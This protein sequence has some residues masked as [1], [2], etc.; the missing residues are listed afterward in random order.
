MAENVELKCPGCGAPLGAP[1]AN[2]DHRC[3]YCGHTSRP[4]APG[5]GSGPSGG[6]LGVWMARLSREQ[7]KQRAGRAEV[8]A[9]ERAEAASAQRNGLLFFTLFGAAF[10][11]CG[12]VLCVSTPPA[13]RLR[14]VI[15]AV[16][17][18]AITL[19][20]IGSFR[21]ERKQRWLL[22]NGARGRGTVLS[23]R[24]RG[25]KFDLVLRVELPNRPPYELKTTRYM[26]PHEDAVFARA[27][28]VMRVNPA[29]DD[30]F[31]F[32]W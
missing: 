11:A 26:D 16:V 8:L 28:L 31:V 22:E 21:I 20:G 29:K 1:A 19:L 14:G 32:E 25:R 9:R 17:G 5:S 30:D 27:E 10:F 7:E 2:G 15:F 23:Y 6:D 18:L 24:K 12:L 3:A 13:G 4:R